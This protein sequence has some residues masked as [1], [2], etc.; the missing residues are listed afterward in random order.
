MTTERLLDRAGRIAGVV[1]VLLFL[2]DVAVTPG[3]PDEG[4]SAAKIAGYYLHHRTGVLAVSLL[5]ALA[6]LA[7]LVFVAALVQRLSGNDEAR[8]VARLVGYAAVA[9]AP[10]ALVSYVC[11][12]AAAYLAG[13]GAADGVVQALAE[14]RFVS[15][16]LADVPLAVFVAAG[17][18]AA[19]AA[20]TQGRRL[21]WLGVV[22]SVAL[23][24]GVVG[25]YNPAS[26]LGFFGFLGSILF[27]VWVLV[28]SL[29]GGS[30]P[31]TA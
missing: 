22:A 7:F 23:V 17:S 18:L 28:A 20:G 24:L 30:R 9:T 31:R 10:V 12:G 13:H 2:A 27:A 1:F 8:P 19:V 14:L 26:V 21:G 4:S 25:I 3:E 16:G 29:G 6:G 15:S 11:A 5:H